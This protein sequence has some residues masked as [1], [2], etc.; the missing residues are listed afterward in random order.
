[1]INV[2]WMNRAMAPRDEPLN[3]DDPDDNP[4]DNLDDNNL[5]NNDQYDDEYKANIEQVP[6]DTLAQLASTISSLAHST[7]CPTSESAPCTKI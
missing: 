6:S 2:F 3:S 5:F 7:H 4:D 1:M